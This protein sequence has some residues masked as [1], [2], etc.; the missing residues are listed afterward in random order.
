MHYRCPCDMGESSEPGGFRKGRKS[1]TSRRLWPDEA[2]RLFNATSQTRCVAWPDRAKKSEV[3]L[4]STTSGGCVASAIRVRMWGIESVVRA[5]GGKSR[6]HR[7]DVDPLRIRLF[8][9]FRVSVG[10]RELQENDWRRRKSAGLVKLLALAPGRRLHRERAAE[11]LRPGW[12]PER[13]LNN[14]NRELHAARKVLQPRDPDAELYL[15]L[16]NRWLNDPFKTLN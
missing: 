15:C 1:G 7:G 8:G 2:F 14:P 3:W 9:G 11:L 6:P 12:S 10:S 16:R 4:K 5:F 13:S